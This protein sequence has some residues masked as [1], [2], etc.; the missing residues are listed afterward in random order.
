MSTPRRPAPRS[1]GAPMIA[2]E[3]SGIPCD[4][5][6]V[7]Y[8][9]RGYGMVS[10]TCS[11]PQI[12]ATTRSTPMPKPACGTVPI[13]T[14]IEIP[15][16]RFAREIVLFKALQEQV[17]VVNALPASDDLAITFGRNDVSPERQFGPVR[18]G[19]EVE[20][21]DLGRVTVD[22]ERPVQIPP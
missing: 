11:R 8:S 20:S 2:I 21:F 18:I 15:V 7:R 1:M 6:R 5:G 13:L 14:Q 12:Q 9:M 22:D 10:R 19:L 3:L 4:Y 17:K 16:E